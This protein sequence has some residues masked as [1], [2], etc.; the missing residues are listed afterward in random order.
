VFKPQIGRLHRV[1]NIDPRFG[2]ARSYFRVL[3]IGQRGP[4]VLLLT[5]ADLDKIQ[6]RKKM[7]PEET[8]RPSITDRLWAWIASFWSDPKGIPP[9]RQ[10]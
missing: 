9:L 2:A 10:P 5:H 7:N 1:D 3:V 4:E 6:R 8:L